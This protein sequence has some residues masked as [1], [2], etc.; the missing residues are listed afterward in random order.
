MASGSSDYRTPRG[1]ALLWASELVVAGSS[2]VFP[3]ALG[4]GW[5]WGP[6]VL[7]VCDGILG[8]AV[9][10]LLSTAATVLLG[11]LVPLALLPFLR[12]KA[13]TVSAPTFGGMYF[14][15]DSPA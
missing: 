7:G 10:A 9:Y 11:F 12:R 6:F 4:H 15:G 2:V 5:H 1:R 3:L 8:I 14:D 13:S